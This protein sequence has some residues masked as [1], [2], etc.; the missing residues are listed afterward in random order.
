MKR[1]LKIVALCLTVVAFTALF[2]GCDMLDEMKANHALLS[3]DQETISFRGETYKRLSEDANL[4]FTY[5]YGNAFDK[6]RVTDE[7]VPVLLSDTYC[8][9]SQYDET[10][11]IFRVNI[12]KVSEIR[13]NEF[14]Y[15]YSYVI[16]DVNSV[17]FCNEKDY[18]KYTTAIN[19]AVLDRI[20]FEYEKET[21]FY[22]YYYT[23]E[24][25]SQEVSEEIFGYIKNPEK[26]NKDVYDELV[27]DYSYDC[28]MSN[29]Y[30]CDSEGLLVEP[31]DGYD[32]LRDSEGNA[33][34]TNHLT[35][36][37]VKLSDKTSDALKDKYF[38]G[39]YQFS[40]DT[41]YSEFDESVS[42]IGGA[43]EK[44]DIFV[45]A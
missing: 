34:L 31:L 16:D 17:Y 18:D 9:Y 25:A 15:T 27:E 39:D 45:T 33:Y 29:I 5:Y 13:N 26:M 23:L 32:I 24:V 30:K 44:T 14:F 36:T 37:I 28:L 2:T 40:D 19:N 1:T 35:E 6:I 7:E 41:E 8:Y 21:E 42:I 3:E 20:G 4:Y 10:K 43:D 12:T 38:Y 22:S 11:D